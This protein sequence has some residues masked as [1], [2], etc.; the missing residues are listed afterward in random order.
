MLTWNGRLYWTDNNA[1]EFQ[2]N[3]INPDGTDPQNE[4]TAGYTGNPQITNGN[5]VRKLVGF[6]YDKTILQRVDALF[7]LTDDG[8]LFRQD[9]HP[10]AYDLI[11]VDTGV[12]DF[13]LRNETLRVGF[14][15]VF[16]WAQVSGPAVTLS[17][18]A[19]A[20]ASFVATP[21]TTPTA[22]TFQ[23]TVSDGSLASHTNTTL[24]LLPTQRA[25]M[26]FAAW[27]HAFF[28]A[29][30]LTNPAVSGVPAGPDGDGV[31]N[32][33]EY[34]FDM[35]P[36]LADGNAPVMQ[37]GGVPVPGSVSALNPATQ[38]NQ[39]YLT[40]TFVRWKDPVDLACSVQSS[41]DLVQWTDQLTSPN[42][43]VVVSQTDVAGSGQLQLVTVRAA[44]PMS[45]SGA[46]PYQFFRVAVTP[47]P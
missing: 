10:R 36:L 11:T 22:L 32:L 15:F 38:T 21:V 7:I 2:V 35:N 3:S 25:R 17:N 26:T 41:L 44:T 24:T 5:H 13:A 42:A 6:T 9:V 28:S 18:I 31:V 23:L 27:S 43:F 40:I 34:A 29:N 37:G 8:T 1:D 45:G 33:L 20:S 14:Q 19:S 46:A 30:Q 39:N 4:L 47:T 16:R 12:Q